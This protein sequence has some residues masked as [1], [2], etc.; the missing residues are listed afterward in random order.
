MHLLHFRPDIA[1]GGGE[2]SR[3]PQD[4]QQRGGPHTSVALPLPLQ[5]QQQRSGFGEAFGGLAAL[6]ALTSGVS[7]AA[8]ADFVPPP[9]T[10]TA[11]VEQQQQASLTF[12]GDAVMTAPAVA[13][14][15]ALP[16]GTQ[17]R[18]SEFIKAVQSGKVGWLACV[19]CCRLH[20]G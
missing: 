19:H 4:W 1:G 12:G 6:L 9:P 15:D 2:P 10:N 8:A 5:A 13:A 20:D 18:Y 17:W 16:E 3:S 11:V 7:P 14:T